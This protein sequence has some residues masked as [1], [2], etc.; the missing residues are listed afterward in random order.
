MK[1]SCLIAACALVSLGSL[2]AATDAE[3]EFDQ[4]IRER[5]AA[6]AE[7]TLPIAQK[8][9][10]ALTALMQ[11][12]T[13]ANDLDTA[14]RI[15]QTL[16]KLAEERDKTAVA[17][18]WDFLNKADGHTAPLEFNSDMT[19]SALGKRLGI[20]EIKGKELIAIHDNREIGKDVYS[21]PIHDGE[22]NGSNRRG[23]ALLLKRQ[24]K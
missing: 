20:W 1:T 13:Q 14:V 22:L 23:H 5:D 6:L 4:L 15:K 3:R 8:Y 21:L 17:G 16:A 12:A 9:E 10:A 18:K 19:F 24:S 11:K 7:A 2:Y